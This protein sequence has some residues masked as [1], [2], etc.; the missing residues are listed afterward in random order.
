MKINLF[1]YLLVHAILITG[2]AIAQKQNGS[3]GRDT[4]V[5]YHVITVYDTVYIRDTIRVPLPASIK[6]LPRHHSLL[7]LQPGK[8]LENG[9]LLI[10]SGNKAISIPV[11]SIIAT[12]DIPG[13][14][15][16]NKLSFFGVMSLVFR[17]MVW[18]QSYSGIYA[19]GGTWWTRCYGSGTG[20][21]FA[22]QFFAGGYIELP[23]WKRMTFMPALGYTF[24]QHNGGYKVL[25]DTVNMV[26]IGESESATNWHQITVPLR[27]NY[28]IGH[29]QPS[30]GFEYAYRFSESWL[31]KG[32]N[33]FGLTAGVRYLIN[34]H[35]SIDLQYYLGLT[36]DYQVSGNSIVSNYTNNT[37]NYDYSWK[38]NRV[39]LSMMYSF[40]R[41]KDR[42]P[43]GSF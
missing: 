33:C 22:A 3:G 5:M 7:L 23:V 25:A 18:S 31:H 43:P 19:G 12:E 27:M 13:S 24:L 26:T 39:G 17:N 8:N 14:A 11:N 21:T 28:R 9:T 42:N 29:F 4:L 41:P 2:H 40:R 20:K 35:F 37:G 6:P 15:I 30:L 34:T 36:T 10:I 38:S 16:A 1:L 32:I